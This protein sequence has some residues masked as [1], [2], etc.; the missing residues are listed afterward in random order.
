MLDK[1]F[2]SVSLAFP[3]IPLVVLLTPIGLD[4]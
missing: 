4:V 1:A 2:V 3:L